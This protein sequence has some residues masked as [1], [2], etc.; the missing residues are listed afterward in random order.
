MSITTKEEI[1]KNRKEFTDKLKTLSLPKGLKVGVVLIHGLTGMP[2]EMR[3]TEKAFESIGC[4]VVTPML[5]GHGGTHTD[6]LK[7]KWRDWVNSVRAPLRELA[8]RC[9]QVY[10]GGLSMGALMPVLLAVEEPKVQGIFSMSPTIK[11]DAQNSSN[12]A[13]VFIPLVDLFPFLGDIFYWTEK[14]PYGLKDERLVKMITKELEAAKNSN[15]SGADAE[16]GFSQF[17]TYAKSLRQLQ[18]LVAQVKKQAPKVQCPVL[19]L[20]SLEDTITTAENARIFHSWLTGCS[21]KTIKFIDGCDHVLPADLKKEEVAYY[22][23][24]FACR[25]ANA[26]SG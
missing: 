21:D 22:C 1:S 26:H 12:P 3:S 2:N 23:A 17:R 15:G 5:A 9:D 10:V 24:E 6:L 18:H 25:I 7:T 4:E 11:Y 20:H 13:Q 14:P 16:S 8:N 19:I